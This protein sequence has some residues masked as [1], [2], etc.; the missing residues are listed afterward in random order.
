MFNEDQMRARLAPPV[1]K[2][3]AILDSDTYNEVDDQFALAYAAAS[4]DRINLIGVNAAPFL[5]ARVS[6]EQEGMER[7][8][9]E[10]GTILDLIHRADIP[11]YRGSEHFMADSSSPVNSAAARNIIDQALSMPE[12][13]P[14][15][16]IGI[17]AP[18]NIASAILMEPEIINRIVVLW[19]GG[20]PLYWPQTWEFNLMQ[21]MASS[22]V[23]FDSGVPLITIPCM[24]VASGLA[25]TASEL[26]AHLKDRNNIGTYLTETV[27]SFS[28]DSNDFNSYNDIVN[29]Y[30]G[31][32]DDFDLKQFDVAFNA[33]RYAWSKVI[34]DISTVAYLVNPGWVYSKCVQAPILND[35]FTWGERIND[36]HLMRSAYYL[37]RDAIFG[38]LFYKIAS[39]KD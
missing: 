19:L 26:S 13:E 14:L 29:K 38:D 8:Y 21:D 4:T 35:D 31:G 16:V 32:I 27:E 12:G 30:L 1:G 22:K 28:G 5:N 18:T 24:S 10:I 3:T 2:V 9:Q 34:W 33:D 37:N 7:S 17:G 6:S 11:A 20:H 36:Q 23:L 15:Y 25:T 39:I